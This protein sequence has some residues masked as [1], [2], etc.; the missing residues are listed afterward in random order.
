M[1]ILKA[2]ALSF[3]A[4]IHSVTAYGDTGLFCPIE[5]ECFDERNDF[6]MLDIR[7]KALIIIDM[8]KENKIKSK[9]KNLSVLL[10]V[11]LNVLKE[12]HKKRIE[13]AQSRIANYKEFLQGIN[14]PE[15]I[16][17]YLLSIEQ[18]EKAIQILEESLLQVKQWKRDYCK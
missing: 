9:E 18:Q 11:E 10:E 6:G 8:I 2:L 12:K 4:I 5:F 16:K 15:T 14:D 1:K 7:S 13:Q 3:I 17:N